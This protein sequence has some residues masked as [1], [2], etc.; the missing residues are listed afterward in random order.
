MNPQSDDGALVRAREWV[1]RLRPDARMVNLATADAAGKPE[2]S[3][4]PAAIAEDGVITVLVSGLARHTAN[5]RT[6]PSASVLM[7]DADVEAARASPL[8]VPRISLSCRV[9][10]L[11]RESPQWPVALAQFQA[12]FGDVIAVVSA[13]SDFGCFRLYPEEGRLVM[14]FGQA[15]HVDPSDWTKL[16]RLA[17]RAPSNRPER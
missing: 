16:S 17:P 8:A 3:L 5:L 13:L 7:T 9:E 4:V 6:N 15:F 11:P 14:G 2:A 1:Q 12:R 10:P